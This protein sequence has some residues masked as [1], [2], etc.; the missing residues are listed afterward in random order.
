MIDTKENRLI[1]VLHILLV[2]TDNRTAKVN[3]LLKR[4][5]TYL[6]SI[7]R[8]VK[9]TEYL[10]VKHKIGKKL[11][12]CQ[13]KK[14]WS[15]EYKDWEEGIAKIFNEETK[16][17]VIKTGYMCLELQPY[18]KDIKYIGKGVFHKAMESFYFDTEKNKHPTLTEKDIRN[19]SDKVAEKLL[20]AIGYEIHKSPLSLK[21]KILEQN[22]ILEGK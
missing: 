7:G 8:T 18:F 13:V 12:M 3:A 22:R 19:Q 4:T 6:E 16:G 9:T 10:G 15:Q 11:P 2:L 14:T 1:L 5:R 20:L 21:K 17:T